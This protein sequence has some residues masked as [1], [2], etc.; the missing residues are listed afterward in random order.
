MSKI[1]LL[2]VSHVRS[3]INES[4][5]PIYLGPGSDI[6]LLNGYNNLNKKIDEFV[7]K[8]IFSNDD[9]VILN[10]GEESVRFLFRNELYPHVLNN[11]LWDTIYKN[12]I[13][14]FNNRKNIL[15]N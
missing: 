4:I 15:D 2:G 7:N 9:I 14:S 13:M 6:N 3:F 1:F 10:I 11:K 5:I 12:D 8:K